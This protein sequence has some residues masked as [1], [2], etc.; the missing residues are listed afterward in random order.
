MLPSLWGAM[1][2]PGRRGLA[3]TEHVVTS[4]LA[5]KVEARTL[6]VSHLS[7]RVSMR[8]PMYRPPTDRLTQTPRQI[9]ARR[10]QGQPIEMG[11]CTRVGSGATKAVIHGCWTIQQQGNPSTWAVC[12]AK[13]GRASTLILLPPSA[14]PVQTMHA[15]RQTIIVLTTTAT[16]IDR[17][18][19]TSTMST[20]HGSPT[21]PPPHGT[22][23]PSSCWMLTDCTSGKP[24]KCAMAPASRR[25]RPWRWWKTLRIKACMSRT[26]T[27][28]RC[29]SGLI[30]CH[31]HWV[32][33]KGFLPDRLSVPSFSIDAATLPLALVNVYVTLAYYRDHA[34]PERMHHL[35]DLPSTYMFKSP[36][37][38]HGVC[39]P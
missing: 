3:V 5:A 17:M 24:S 18:S 28:G 11:D 8:P 26:R 9:R 22:T 21:L 30:K 23:S 33:S 4:S 31:P 13:H 32:T 20:R 6:C 39:P 1:P 34:C 16:R 37:Q 2:P 15:S 29:V 27:M 19:H 36:D 25:L 12:Q 10:H 35:C 7:S 14:H 38:S